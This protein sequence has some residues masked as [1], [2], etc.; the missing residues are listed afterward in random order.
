[1]RYP[2]SRGG[3]TTAENGQGLCE[4]CNYAKQAR[5]GWRVTSGTDENGTHA[6][7]FITP[8]GAHY[9]SAAPPMPGTPKIPRST[10]ELYL[11][12]ELLRVIAA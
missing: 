2:H 8:T 3:A 7:E 4:A 1:M 5:G 12:G 10:A 11:N 6:T 9:H